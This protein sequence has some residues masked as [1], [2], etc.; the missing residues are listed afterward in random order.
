M[1]SIRLVLGVLCL[2]LITLAPEPVSTRS[3]DPWITGDLF[4]GVGT[5]KVNRGRIDV[6]DASGKPR[7]VSIQVPGADAGYTTGCY[8]NPESQT[9]FASTFSGRSLHEFE[10]TTPI[11]RLDLAALGAGVVAAESLAFA[12]GGDR[13]FVALP[14]SAPQLVSY[15]FSGHSGFSDPQ[16]YALPPGVGRSESRVDWIDVGEENGETVVYYTE[17]S[18]R[19]AANTSHVY[20]YVPATGARTV[21][22]SVPEGKAYALRLLPAGSG[23]LVAGY[24]HIYRFNM[25][26]QEVFRYFGVGPDEG[27]FFALNITPDGRHFWSATSDSNRPAAS[28]R[29]HKFSTTA[30]RHPILS[31]TTG[32]PSI[33][34]LCLKL[35]Y[36]AARNVCS[37]PV[38]G[39]TITCPRLEVCNEGPDDDGDGL[40]DLADPDCVL[41]SVQERCDDLERAD[42]N[43]NGLINEGCTTTTP[44][45]SGVSLSFASQPVSG[46]TI[47]YSATGLPPGLTMD[48]NGAVTGTTPDG[49]SATYNVTLTA[50]RS[51]T[52]DTVVS[53][54]WTVADVNR[55]PSVTTTTAVASGT[56]GQSL[57]LAIVSGADPDTATDGDGWT[58]SALGLPNGLAIDAASGVISGTPAYDAAG[59]HTVTISVTDDHASRSTASRPLQQMNLSSSTTIVLNVADGNPGDR[60]PA[61]DAA[62]SSLP[63][64]LWPPNFQLAE[65]VV[66]GVVDADGDPVTIRIHGIQQD[67]PTNTAGDGNTTADGVISADGRTAFVRAERDGT[68]KA[69]GDGRVYEI[70]FT[71]TTPTLSCSGMVRVGVP[72]DRRSSPLPVRSPPTYNSLTGA[73][74]N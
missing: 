62:V 65:V 50:D 40:N 45:R 47:T 63:M 39:Q 41:P 57:H 32:A 69:P 56:E 43:R 37:D 61:C 74:I 8:Y 22:A 15:A 60:A 6:Y 72:F 52:G 27:A 13:L 59:S 58:F 23:L 53:H 25:Q 4:V 55:A 48:S 35:E 1:R 3:S 28:G 33:S 18:A 71:A 54:V 70:L 16:T 7:G 21:F 36:T 46:D 26:G 51:A 14:Y 73:R 64:I 49:A 68:L 67:E 31:V 20:R 5:D 66:L 17:E 29:L 2:A 30:S 19:P 9:L 38:T 42:E 11:R 12:P 34:G 44:E 24:G 10:G